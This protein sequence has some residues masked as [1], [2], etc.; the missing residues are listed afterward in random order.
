M[1]K[2][3]HQTFN[4]DIQQRFSLVPEI[5]GP[6]TSLKEPNR[7]MLSRYKAL[8]SIILLSFLLIRELD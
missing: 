8:L 1:L 7:A 4:Q 2:D 3:I 6:R 5:Q